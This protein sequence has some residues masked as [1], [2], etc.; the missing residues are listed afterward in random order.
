MGVWE[1]ETLANL[2][3]M[4]QPKTISKKDMTDDGDYPVYGA[5]GIIGRYNSYNH[6]SP[7]LLVTCRGATCGSVNITSGKVWINGNA[8]VIAP[9]DERLVLS[10]LEYFFRGA[11]DLSKVISGA[12]QPQITRQ[13]LSPVT[14]DYPPIPEQQRIVA[15]LDQAFAD[16]EKARANAESNLKNARELFD[17]YLNQVFRQR[18]EG[19]VEETLGQATGGVYTGPFGSLLHK[20]DYIV[21]GIP[22]INPAHITETG[23]TADENKSVSLEVAE[24]LS[25]YLMQEG[26]IV[27]GRRGEMGRCALVTEKEDGFLCGTG[28]F[29]IKSSNRCYGEYLVHFLRSASCKA[30]LESIAGGA[31]MP[32]L[33]NK[34][35][36]SFTL[37]LPSYDIQKELAAEIDLVAKRTRNVAAVYEKKL[38]SLDE[39]K[40]SL[41]HKA[42]SGELT[43]TVGHAA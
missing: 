8:M 39:L 5:N 23:I 43:K 9:K 26:D 14:V 40:K 13:G 1:T 37:Y 33:S 11:I 15:I 22:L 2:C 42:F 29:F 3:N 30:R 20:S 7:Q 34:D 35:L 17:S 12:A 24:R 6:D 41:L 21:N 18:G 16:I 10:Y 32:N 28:S 4:Y 36:S 27:I 25:S 19:W 31:V 38:A